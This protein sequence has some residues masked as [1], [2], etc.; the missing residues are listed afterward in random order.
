MKGQAAPVTPSPSFPCPQ[1]VIPAPEPESRALVHQHRR[2]PSGAA[3]QWGPSIV[4]GAGGALDSSSQAP[5]NDMPGPE[6]RSPSVRPEGNRRGNG[7][8]AVVGSQPL[9][10]PKADT[11]GGYAAQP[12]RPP[13][14][15]GTRLTTPRQTSGKPGTRSAPRIRRRWTAQHSPDVSWPRW[16]RSPGRI[17]GPASGS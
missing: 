16:A 4:A 17:R 1:P 6:R 3:Q 7:R 12:K 5:R 8:A 15:N 9:P 14:A 2:I 11:Q 10:L 13:A